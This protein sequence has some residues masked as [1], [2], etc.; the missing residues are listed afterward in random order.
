MNVDDVDYQGL[1]EVIRKENERLRMQ[2]VGL[3]DNGY[4]FRDKVGDIIDNIRNNPYTL[5]CILY[6]VSIAFQL[7][8]PLAKWM[9]EKKNEK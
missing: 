6:A 3:K 8:I 2:I 7:I 5:I 9:L 1:F 4:T